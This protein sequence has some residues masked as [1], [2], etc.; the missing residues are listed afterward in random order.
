MG[1][2]FIY[3]VPV[4]LILFSCGEPGETEL[5]I[6]EE[7]IPVEITEND[8]FKGNIIMAFLENEK[9][10]IKEANAFFLKGIDSYRNKKDYDSAEFYLRRSLLKEPTAQAYFELG[11][12]NMDKK[13]YDLAMKSYGMAEQLDYQPF[14]KILYN[15]ACIYSLQDEV[16]Q[17]GR[18]LEYALQA[19]YNNVEHID[20]DPDLENLRKNEWSFRRSIEK[21]LRGT[22]DAEDLFWLQFKKRFPKLDFPMKLATSISEEQQDALQFISFDYEKYITEMR[23]EQFSREVSKGFYYFGLPYENDNFVALIYIVRDE[24]MGND[25]PLTYRLATYTHEG[26]LIDKVD[27]AGRDYYGDPFKAATINQN[28][29]IDIDYLEVEYEKDPGSYGYYD[30]EIISTQSIGKGTIKVDKYGKLTEK[31]EDLAINE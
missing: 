9:K 10:F 1:K 15:K 8:L 17:A 6:R 13:D 29:T 14:S 7:R 19:G 22:S 21:G 12:L 24:F 20:K 25:A 3:F 30:N 11:N 28:M 4:L 26:E 27:L 31:S 5:K 23:D 16:D 2:C 18:Y